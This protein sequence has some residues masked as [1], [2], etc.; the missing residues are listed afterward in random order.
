LRVGG[1]EAGPAEDDEGAD[2]VESL[3]DLGVPK[4]EVRLESFFGFF[5]SDVEAVSGSALRFS[6][7]IGPE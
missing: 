6:V 3:A 7:A 4:K 2:F 5:K 1:S